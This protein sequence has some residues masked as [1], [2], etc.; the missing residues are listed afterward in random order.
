M[1]VVMVKLLIYLGFVKLWLV[2]IVVLRVNFNSF[3]CVVYFKLKGDFFNE[4]KL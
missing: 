1:C 2:L 3:C 4:N